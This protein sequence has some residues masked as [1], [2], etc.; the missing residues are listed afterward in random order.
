MSN[1]WSGFQKDIPELGNQKFWEPEVLFVHTLSW[2]IITYPMP[3]KMN[4][5]P[6]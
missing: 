5:S 1:L 2:A 6:P 4:L 3:E